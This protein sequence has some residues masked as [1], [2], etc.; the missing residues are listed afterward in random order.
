M[1]VSFPSKWEATVPKGFVARLHLLYLLNQLEHSDGAQANPFDPANV[2]FARLDGSGAF[3]F[4]SLTLLVQTFILKADADVVLGR[5]PADYSGMIPCRKEIEEFEQF[6]LFRHRRDELST[7]FSDYD[8][9]AGLLPDGQAGCWAFRMRCAQRLPLTANGYEIEYDLLAAAVDAQLRVAYTP[10]LP[11]PRIARHSGVSTGAIEMSIRKLEFIRRKLRITRG[12][13]AQAW[14]DFTL[15][16][17]GTNVVN[18][19]LPGY[20]EELVRVYTAD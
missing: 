10:P 6:L 15:D 4:D 19:I 1:K 17:G 2:V 16:F 9:S 20:G 18:N 5:R 3:D 14:R 11:M 13:I 7:C 8:L 12:H